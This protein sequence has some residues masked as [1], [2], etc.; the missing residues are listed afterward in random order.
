MICFENV[1]FKYKNMNNNV[2]DNV[3]LSIEDG[4]FIVVLGRNGSG[5]STLAK[6]I[7]GMLCP[8][9]GTV[10][11]FGMD[12]SEENNLKKVHK[13]VGMVFQNPENQIVHS[14]VEEEVAFVPENLCLPRETIRKRV[15]EALE[16]VGMEK[17]VLAGT[18]SLSGGQQQRIAVAGVLAARP[19][20]IVFDEATSMLDPKGRKDILEL[21]H[22]LNYE[23]GITIVWITHLMREV[24]EADRVIV[25]NKGKIFLDDRPEKI[26]ASV[27]E[28]ELLG[29]GVPQVYEFFYKL[30]ESLQGHENSPKFDLNDLDGC[31]RQLKKL[32]EK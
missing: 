11:V 22:K 18:H 12:T 31:V 27:E 3:T 28:M 24:K 30:N 13:N 2:L 21:A 10:N 26:M 1:S 7:N 32:L 20:C 4:S 16:T 17:Y 19:K 6:H 9:E 25:M 8:T 14:I 23:E 29:L 15:D 5:K